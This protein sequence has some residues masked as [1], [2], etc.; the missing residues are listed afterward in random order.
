MRLPTPIADVIDDIQTAQETLTD[1][2]RAAA[3]L[4]LRVPAGEDALALALLRDTTAD[5]VKRLEHARL[6]LLP[7]LRQEEQ[8]NKN[9]LAEQ[10]ERIAR[11]ARPGREQTWAE[12][13]RQKL[14]GADRR[15]MAT[16]IFVVLVGFLTLAVV[17]G[18]A[19]LLKGC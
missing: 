17:V 8:M 18:A 5:A 2:S 11:K 1:N 19:S 3:R 10:A 14:D 16:A 9:A 6:I 4:T 13:Q 15:R 7:Q 12:L